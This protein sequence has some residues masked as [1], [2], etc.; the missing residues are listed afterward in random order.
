MR[1]SENSYHQPVSQASDEKEVKGKRRREVFISGGR[2]ITRPAS[3]RT[4]QTKK[5]ALSC[6]ERKVSAPSERK[7]RKVERQRHQKGD[8]KHPT[9]DRG[10]KKL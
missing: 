4:R 3:S 7:G 9:E 2:S 10:R 5:R 6:K 8:Q 1:K